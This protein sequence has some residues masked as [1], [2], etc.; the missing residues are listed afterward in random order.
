MKSLMLFVAAFHVLWSTASV[1]AVAA[2]P[3]VER[4]DVRAIIAARFGGPVVLAHD[5]WSIDIGQD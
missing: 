3:P 4:V 5:G 2:S 1:C